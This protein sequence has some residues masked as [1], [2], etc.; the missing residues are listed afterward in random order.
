MFGFGKKQINSPSSNG[1]PIEFEIG[2]LEAT[3]DSPAASGSLPSTKPTDNGTPSSAATPAPTPPPSGLFA[4]VAPVASSP[5]PVPEMASAPVQAPLPPAASPSTTPQPV[6]SEPVPISSAKPAEINM[7]DKKNPTSQSKAET[8]SL[9]MLEQVMADHNEQDIKAPDRPAIKAP[10]PP[11]PTAMPGSSPILPPP[12]RMASR[13]GTPAFE[14]NDTTPLTPK[15]PSKLASKPQS[16]FLANAQPTKSLR[17]TIPVGQNNPPNV[18]SSMGFMAPVNHSPVTKE[19][20]L[21]K[22]LLITAVT[23]L[24][25]TVGAGLYYYF[26]ILKSPTET[27][28][29]SSSLGSSGDV[30]PS[31]SSK[32]APLANTESIILKP[33]ESVQVALKRQA[34]QMKNSSDLPEKI[35]YNIK[36]GETALDSEKIMTGLGLQINEYAAE[37]S[38][39]WVFFTKAPDTTIKL[40]LIMA[41]KPG[42]QLAPKVLEKENSLPSKLSG[43]FIDEAVVVPEQATFM[44]SKYDPRVRFF[45]IGNGASIDYAI[46]GSEQNSYWLIATSKDTIQDMLNL[47]GL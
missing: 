46:V 13:P 20:K 42:I 38:E 19:S 18:P 1:G 30:T 8:P 22:I 10:I 3:T 40:G 25:I 45:N 39:S 41:V 11:E 17:N 44:P 33:G 27:T 31:Q 7:R 5:A 26:Y 9:S 2:A 16:P 43:M 37:L 36:N 34:A 47:L 6:S 35:L 24:L 29:S 15:A 4:N 23:I 12:Q 14:G 32:P 21:N 28:D